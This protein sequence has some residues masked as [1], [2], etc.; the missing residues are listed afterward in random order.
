MARAKTRAAR[1]LVTGKESR[2]RRLCLVTLLNVAARCGR[3]MQRMRV[4]FSILVLVFLVVAREVSAQAQLDPPR[5]VLSSRQR[6]IEVNISN[7]TNK[8]LE[9]TIDLQY[10]VIGY[11]SLGN[12]SILHDSLTDEAR[13]RDC[14]S[15]LKVFPRRLVLPST[16]S[17]TVRI[18]A[19]IP[20]NTPEGEYWSRLN[21][22]CVPT[23]APAEL[24]KLD[25]GDVALGVS[26]SSVLSTPILVRVGTISTGATI[27]DVIGV[28][29]SGQT[30]L[31][32]SMTRTGNS[33]YRGTLKAKVVDGSGTQV[34]EGLT[35]TT[36]EFAGRARVALR[37]ISDGTY[38]V[39]IDGTTVRR[40]SMSEIV[41]P[42]DPIAKTY[43]MTVAGSQITMTPTN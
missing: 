29:D 4:H 28:V 36:I 18:L 11:D 30:T 43:T 22:D 25:S 40:G 6:S 9:V 24:P 39:Q 16:S 8:P 1:P 5:P 26:M 31:I 41:V 19:G 42:A 7:P 32:C 37:S 14:S 38:Q 15:W 10:T 20:A 13:S 33:P 23:D 35:E 27:D 21:L 3:I 34:A 2:C 17:R 12:V